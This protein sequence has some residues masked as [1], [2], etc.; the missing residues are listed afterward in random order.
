M[1][2]AGENA[3]RCST[4]ALRLASRFSGVMTCGRRPGSAS[5]LLLVVSRA[6]NLRGDCVWR[7]I[8]WQAIVWRR[9]NLW[10]SVWRACK[11]TVGQS[12]HRTDVQHATS[13][14][15]PDDR[16]AVNSSQSEGDREAGEHGAG[17]RKPGS[18]SLAVAQSTIDNR[19][20]RLS[21]GRRQWQ[22]EQ[23]QEQE[24]Q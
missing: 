24:Q 13:T 11:R 2:E 17:R 20:T 15:K 10:P 16:L 6:A 22:Q 23:E 18:P 12:D 5:Y 9:E 3:G 8:V 21:A 1:S 14:S 19:Q 7:A 4:T